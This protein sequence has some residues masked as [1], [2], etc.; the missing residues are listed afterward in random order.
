[1]IVCNDR[2]GSGNIF[3]PGFFLSFFF[4]V[5]HQP[6]RHLKTKVYFRYFIFLA[7]ALLLAAGG[8]GAKE[9]DKE[10]ES[11]ASK[12]AKAKPPI[13]L[14]GYIPVQLRPFSVPVRSLDGGLGRGSITMF[15]TVRGKKNVESFCRYLPRVREAITLTVDR[16][17]IPVEESGYRL[18]AIGRQLHQSINRTLP[19]PLVVKLHV[20]PVPWPIGKGAVDLELPGTGPHCMAIQ[21]L[22]EDVLK[23]LKAQNNKEKKLSTYRPKSQP[24]IPATSIPALPKPV[25]RP[26]RPSYLPPSVMVQAKK[27]DLPVGETSTSGNC[28]NLKDL[29][30]PGYHQVSG[31]QY[32]LEK[33]FTLDND[34]DE[35]VDNVGFVL[36][37]GERPDLYIYYFP[38]QGRQS[39]ITAPS[40]RLAD[41]RNVRMTCPGQLEYMESEA[42][43]E[44]SKGKSKPGGGFF[45][46]PG[47]IFATAT[48]A[49]LVL[50]GLAG[51]CY[52]RARR[53]KERRREERR[54]QK[55]RRQRNTPREGEDRRTASDRRNEG[56]QRLEQA[57][58]SITASLTERKQSGPDSS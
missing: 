37:S 54:R 31:R 32:W 44:A 52:I 36:K 42:A 38:G 33:A 13:S 55:D 43:A 15:L 5:R 35:V 45:N 21:E 2:W 47:M 7:G 20:L 19:E 12:E 16:S 27:T 41:D 17:P 50:I 22:P 10:K 9:A 53:K 25:S 29:W 49:G 51:V 39:V 3:R 6:F 46:G 23:M 26:A 1:M 4:H 56:A 30:R 34:N 24:D 40:L 18:D 58:K 57:K 14:E 11:G 28:Q 8:V 48:G